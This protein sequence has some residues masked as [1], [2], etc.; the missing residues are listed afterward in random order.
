[1]K[2]LKFEWDNAIG[3][4]WNGKSVLIGQYLPNRENNEIS[5]IEIYGFALSIAD[6]NKDFQLHEYS[7]FG[8]NICGEVSEISKEDARKLLYEEIDKSLNI[9]FDQGEMNMINQK[10]NVAESV[11]ED[12]D[13]D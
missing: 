1:M 10:L 2:I 7:C 5:H 9:L 13:E 4:E 6:I 3:C 12:N 8:G 11:Y